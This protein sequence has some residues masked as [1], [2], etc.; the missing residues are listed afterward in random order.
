MADSKWLD[1]WA[2]SNWTTTNQ[3]VYPGH[4]WDCLKGAADERVAFVESSHDSGFSAA[5]TFPDFDGKLF[6]SSENSPTNA[7]RIKNAIY[8]KNCVDTDSILT[9]GTASSNSDIPDEFSLSDLL[10]TELGYGSGTLKHITDTNSG[11]RPALPLT[12]WYKQWYEVMN[13]P[14][15]YNFDLDGNAFSNRFTEIDRQFIDIVVSYSYQPPEDPSTPDTFN[16]ASADY[17]GTPYYTSGDLNESA[18]WST[19]SDI[20]DYTASILS[21]AKSN[22]AWQ[23]IKNSASSGYGKTHPVGIYT[24]IQSSRFISSAATGRQ[25]TITITGQ[26]TYM[27]LRFKMSDEYRA[28]SPDKFTSDIYWNVYNLNGSDIDGTSDNFDDFGTGESEG[29]ISFLKLTKSGDY[30]YLEP[31]TFGTLTFDQSYGAVPDESGFDPMDSIS[32]QFSQVD[33][34]CMQS[35]SLSPNMTNYTDVYHSIYTNQ[36]K[37]DG[38]GFLW[39]TPPP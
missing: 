31:E 29:G 38:T 10:T 17:N 39:Y 16:S 23:S 22:V 21:T 36:N 27:R 3:N 25:R 19:P 15:Y 18:P 32:Q 5:N 1:P 13:Y 2:I 9:S 30:Y 24:R 35:N 26:L 34:Y 11:Q 8:P 6:I 14:E 37:T 7:V 20:R 28:A 4:I 12:N 33:R